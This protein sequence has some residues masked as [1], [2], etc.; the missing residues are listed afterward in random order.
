MSRV[1][2][3]NGSQGIDYI[4]A[5][6]NEKGFYI[7][8]HSKKISKICIPS[9][10]AHLAIS[11]S[12]DNTIK[13]WN[14][15]TMHQIYSL[16]NLSKVHS[17][18][19]THDLSNILVLADQSFYIIDYQ[20]KS[21][22][23]IFKLE[24]P[25]YEC[26]LSH[27][28]KSIFINEIDFILKFDIDTGNQTRI[29]LD[30]KISKFAIS[31]GNSLLCAVLMPTKLLVYSL[32]S[33]SKIAVLQGIESITCLALTLDNKYCICGS[34][35]GFLVIYDLITLTHIAILSEHFSKVT[36]IDTTSDSKYAIS[37]ADEKKVYIWDLPARSLH[38][39]I[40]CKHQVHSLK[41]SP[42][43]GFILLAAGSSLLLWQGTTDAFQK[44][45]VHRKAVSQ[46]LF[47]RDGKA[48]ITASSD[49]TVCVWNTQTKERESRYKLH[50]GYV[51]CMA[52]CEND[53]FLAYG[54]GDC[55]VRVINL[56]QRSE[57]VFEYFAHLD[58]IRRVA[59]SNRYNIVVSTDISGRIACA[60]LSGKKNA[61]ILGQQMGIISLAILNR[62]YVISCSAKGI[63]VWKVREKILE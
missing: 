46:H 19:I 1:S 29:D 12:L 6:L 51:G 36:C 33:S 45:V 56:E 52:L 20:T 26:E 53:K 62:K 3:Y 44:F 11:V 50:S 55:I 10:S 48:L 22:K 25:A 41:I 17:V 35:T 15:K 49:R 5:C 28:S 47:T 24:I 37:A 63:I 18:L 59:V 9:N 32:I 21:V 7:Y 8:S 30:S 2:F 13:I 38:S 57:S 34:I 40:S 54:C 61:D 31:D 23:N 58:S 4:H 43:G 14:T 42:G 60:G 16:D 27:D 39:T